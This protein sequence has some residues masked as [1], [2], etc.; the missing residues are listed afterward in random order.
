[1]TD[2]D[3]NKLFKQFADSYIDV[4]NQLLEE[5]DSNLVGSSF[6]YGAARF[7]SF[8]VASGS[9]DLDQFKA[10]KENA[11]D[12]FVGQFK[13]MLEENLTNYES[14]FTEEAPKYSQYMKK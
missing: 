9:K 4:G 11:I 1:M 10:N 5:H 14:A 2:A 13:Q 7:S 12:H 3:T 8:I 6:I